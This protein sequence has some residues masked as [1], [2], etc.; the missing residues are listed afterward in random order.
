MLDI[1]DLVDFLVAHEDCVFFV[2]DE[3]WGKEFDEDLLTVALSEI[4]V[5]VF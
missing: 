5:A 2:L 3:L 1:K 4:I